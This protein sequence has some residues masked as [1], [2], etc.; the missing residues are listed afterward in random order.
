[1]CSVCSQ[2]V[3]KPVNVH[4]HA[5]TRAPSCIKASLGTCPSV[6]TSKASVESSQAEAKR[7][8]FPEDKPHLENHECESEHLLGPLCPHPQQDSGSREQ[9][10][11]VAELREGPEGQEGPASAAAPHPPDP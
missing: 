9:L 4:M 3:S 11:C 5:H 2:G 10:F 6:R 1:M 8:V 7:A